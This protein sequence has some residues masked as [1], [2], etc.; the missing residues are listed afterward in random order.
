MTL[1]VLDISVWHADSSDKHSS[2]HV[3]AEHTGFVMD[4]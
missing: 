3:V 1:A 4:A 2:L